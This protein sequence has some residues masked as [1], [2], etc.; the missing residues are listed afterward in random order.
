MIKREEE[1]KLK[2]LLKLPPPITKVS[3]EVDEEE[4]INLFKNGN[5]ILDD[6]HKNKEFNNPEH[7]NVKYL[8]ILE[9]YFTL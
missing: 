3:D 9:N 5:T 1:D 6:L 4:I 2:I 7:L 8:F